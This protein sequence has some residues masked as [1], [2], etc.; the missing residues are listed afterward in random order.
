MKADHPTPEAGAVARREADRELAS[1]GLNLAGDLSSGHFGMPDAVTMIEGLATRLAALSTLPE[2][3]EPSSA[4]EPVAWRYRRRA[5]AY[6]IPGATDGPWT[7]TDAPPQFGPNGDSTYEIKALYDHPAPTTQPADVAGVREDVR[8]LALI[9]L[10]LS[11]GRSVVTADG[12]R[13]EWS[14]GD[15]DAL[16]SDAEGWATEEE[17]AKYAAIMR[18]APSR[19]DFGAL[20]EDVAKI[21]DRDAFVPMEDI[22]GMRKA[23]VLADAILALIH[24]PDPYQGEG[25]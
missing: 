23:L 9:G 22:I 19:S 25:K 20:R 6:G 18:P 14:M 5:H 17:P 2:A 8:S 10:Y 13:I 12:I 7:Y 3:E 1:L 24:K 21:I 16:L 15:R 4:Q 11:Q